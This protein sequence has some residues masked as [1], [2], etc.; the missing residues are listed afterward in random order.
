MREHHRE[1]TLALERARPGQAFVENT[2]EGVHVGASVDH[3]ALDLLG[4]DVVDRAYE[5]ALA[6]Q[7]AHR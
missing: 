7:A 6:G 2:A 3:A 4:R 5:A 1:L